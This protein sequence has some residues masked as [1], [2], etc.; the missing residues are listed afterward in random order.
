MGV[1]EKCLNNTLLLLESFLRKIVQIKFSSV[2]K[3]VK[4]SQVKMAFAEK[5]AN[6]L[7][8]LS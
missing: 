4:G 8:F 3:C 5:V 2:R 1:K 7:D 6:I